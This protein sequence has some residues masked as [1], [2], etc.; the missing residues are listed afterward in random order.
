[1]SADQAASAGTREVLF[2]VIAASL[3]LVCMFTAV[4]FMPG[5]VGIFMRSFAVVV[6]AGVIASLFVS[7]TLTPALCARFLELRSGAT[8]ALLACCT[9]FMPERS[10]FTARCW[11][12]V[13]D[14]AGP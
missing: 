2:P 8:K 1:M 7:L 3:T 9:V 12:A 11:I 14:T 13:F 5:M 10:K 4:I 6:V